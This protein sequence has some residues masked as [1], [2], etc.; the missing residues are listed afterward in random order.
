MAYEA[1]SET[2]KLQ[3]RYEAQEAARKVKQQGHQDATAAADGAAAEG[4]VIPGDEA[5]LEAEAA[6]IQDMEGVEAAAIQD[7]GD[8]GAEDAALDDAA[9]A[10]E[11][12]VEDDEAEAAGPGPGSE[13][14]AAAGLED[15]AAAA[16]AVDRS[17]WQPSWVRGGGNRNRACGGG[18]WRGID[19]IIP[20]EDPNILD[21]SCCLRKKHIMVDMLLLC[22][23]SAI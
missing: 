11:E 16:A 2:Y 17:P 10:A 20:V 8:A 22:N 19:P 6:A 1:A 21:V 12:M 18:R 4:D 15:G 7:M 13:G 23:I 5:E 14:A 9:A 3:R